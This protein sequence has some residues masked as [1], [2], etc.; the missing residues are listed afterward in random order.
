MNEIPVSL[1]IHDQALA[2][3]QEEI[4]LRED[5]ERERLKQ[6]EEKRELEEDQ[7]RVAA[8]IP[9]LHNSFS[10]FL[11]KK[12]S[13]FMPADQSAYIMGTQVLES[14]S[15][16]YVGSVL[17][18][19]VFDGVRPDPDSDEEDEYTFSIRVKRMKVEET[20]SDRFI[21]RYGSLPEN[22]TV[23]SSM[24]YIELPA[25]QR[26]NFIDAI[27]LS[28]LLYE[29]TTDPR[30]IVTHRKAGSVVSQQLGSDLTIERQG[31]QSEY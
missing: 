24:G 17:E 5:L 26:M 14:G 8:M 15:S 20:R 12:V 28:N 2:W 7:L 10:E 19:V 22:Y 16:S 29:L 23:D 4:K 11:V 1:S 9:D 27:N 30:V 18:E 13:G 21:L 25:K 31:F 6:E 3:R